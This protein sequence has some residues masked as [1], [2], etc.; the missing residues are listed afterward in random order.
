MALN[1]HELYVLLE[2]WGGEE[3][4]EERG[5]VTLVLLKAGM[6]HVFF[7]LVIV[8]KL[9]KTKK[10]RKKI[11]RKSLFAHTVGIQP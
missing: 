6:S 4:R 5:E 11:N 1:F 7:A 3:D 2:F 8:R 9:G 10:K